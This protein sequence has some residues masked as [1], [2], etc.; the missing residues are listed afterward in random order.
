MR[1]L[2]DV[3]LLNGVVFPLVAE[4]TAIAEFQIGIVGDSCSGS[5]TIFRPKASLTGAGAGRRRHCG[6]S[7]GGASAAAAG[8][9]VVKERGTFGSSRIIVIAPRKDFGRIS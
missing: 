3:R 1:V 8:H 7:G 9:V 4:T 2:K 6:G 5:L